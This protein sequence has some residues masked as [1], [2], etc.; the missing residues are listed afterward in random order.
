[1]YCSNCGKEIDDKA[2]VCIHCGVATAN[3]HQTVQSSQPVQQQPNII[4][5][6]KA[7]AVSSSGRTRRH[8]SLALD[9][10]MTIF[11]GGLWL[12][13]VWLRPKYY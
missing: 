6:N 8:Y 7:T 9:I 12:F 2:V 4:I 13:W 11:T 3:M 5:N 1:M 10:I